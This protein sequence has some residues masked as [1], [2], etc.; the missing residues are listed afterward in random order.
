MR[1]EDGHILSRTLD[2]MVEGQRKKG[3]SKE[4][5]E[6]KGRRGGQR[7]KGRS[8]EEGEA[9]GRRGG[10]RGHGKSRLMKKA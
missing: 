3:R 5:G 2:L 9:K 8:K 4:E 1:G 7:K 6:V 10:Q